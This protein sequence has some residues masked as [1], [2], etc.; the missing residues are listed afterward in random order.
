M[1]SMKRSREYSRALG[2]ISLLLSES[3][4]CCL[5]SFVKREVYEICDFLDA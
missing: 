5:E 4:L 1:Y 3:D 2:C